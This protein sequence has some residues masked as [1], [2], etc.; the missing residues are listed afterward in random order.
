MKR[1]LLTLTIAVLGFGSVVYASQPVFTSPQVGSSPAN[2]FVLQTNGL[3]S[4]WVATSTLGVG[5]SL[6]LP[7]SIANGGTAT[8]SA[9]TNGVYYSDGTA[10]ETNG[11]F[12]YD[13]SNFVVSPTVGTGNLISGS[14]AIVATSGGTGPFNIDGMN[15]SGIVRMVTSSS[16]L[17]TLQIANSGSGGLITSFGGTSGGGSGINFVGINA[18][19]T[20][21]ALL[22]VAGSA[23]GT[24]PLFMLS[25]STAGFATSTA[26]EIDNNGNASIQ[27]GGSLNMST[28]GSTNY[29]T[30][31]SGNFNFASQNNTTGN[32]FSVGQNTVLF[33]ING[34]GTPK[35]NF[36]GTSGGSAPLITTAITITN[37]SGVATELNVSPTINN[38]STAGYTALSIRPTE[39][40]LGSGNHILLNIGTSTAPDLF[41]VTNLGVA[42][43]TGLNVTGNEVVTGSVTWPA[44]TGTQCLHAINGLVSGTGSD[45]GAGGTN[46]FTN[47]GAFTYLSTGTSLGV[48]TTTPYRTLGVSGGFAVDG[49]ALSFIGLPTPPNTVLTTGVQELLI[50]TSTTITQAALG[51]SND[52]EGSTNANVRGLEAAVIW[53]PNATANNTTNNLVNG[54]GLRNQYMIANNSIGRNVLQAAAVSAGFQSTGTLAST[55]NVNLFFAGQNSS[56]GFTSGNIVT[57]F[58][59]FRAEPGTAAGTITNYAGLSINQPTLATNNTELLIGTST[60]PLGNYGLYQNSADTYPNYFNGNVGFGSTTPQAR[61]TVVAASS[62][63]ATGPYTGLVSII[64]GLE[65]TTVKLFQ[66]IDQWG[67]LITSGDSPNVSGGTSSVSG[68]DNNGTVTVTGTLL[69]SVTLTFAHAWVTAPDCTMSDNSTGITADITSISATQIVFGFS[70]GI[71][72]GIVWYGCKGHQ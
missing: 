39:T 6:S 9:V 46:Y 27:N 67:H 17:K 12:F 18:T 63:V 52:Y 23:G 44:I 54:G 4:T 15:S 43:S 62:T 40:A 66:E 56:G 53:G 68:N 3:N 30:A 64:A 65:N 50:A 59:S 16:V 38:S 48:G 14:V 1:Y 22:S 35:Y 13:G 60:N 42:S 33:T 34:Q 47:S 26:F 21:G 7:L 8:S 31:N 37:T 5:S 72:S 70:T 69:T 45:C 28:S 29:L 20:P 24:T 11:K 32:I 19:S 57:N 49:N 55:T 25:T 41:D 36:A 71:N 51:V 61:L 10:A 58:Y 2:G